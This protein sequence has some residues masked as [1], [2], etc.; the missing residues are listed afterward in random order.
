MQVAKVENK[1]SMVLY[2]FYEVVLL[3]DSN[4]PKSMNYIKANPGRYVSA[5]LPDYESTFGNTVITNIGNISVGKQISRQ[6]SHQLSAIEAIDNQG[7]A[8]YL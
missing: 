1:F 6:F 3:R 4:I 7:S 5:A 8:H 2:D